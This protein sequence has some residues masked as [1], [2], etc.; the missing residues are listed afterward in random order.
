MKNEPRMK[1]ALTN[2]KVQH[3]SALTETFGPIEKPGIIGVDMASE[4][5]QHSVMYY[6]PM[7]KVYSQLNVLVLGHGRHGKDEF[8][9]RLAMR[10][11]IK[12]ASSSQFAC[13]RVVFPWFQ[14]FFPNHYENPE[15]CFN[16]RQNWR[17]L[18]HLLICEYNSEDKTRL[19][20][21][22]M[23][24]NNAYVGM[25]A[26]DELEACMNANIF[27]HVF[28]IDAGDRVEA[29]DVSSCSVEYDYETMCLVD[30][31]GDFEQLQEEVEL[32]ADMLGF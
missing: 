18:W 19:T 23:I 5:D 30:N 1:R 2:Y 17:A 10:I 21:E 16:D 11:G 9:A 14:Q 8:A 24:E 6:D 15:E 3:D 20:R 25:R 31:S 22:I 27:T 26:A 4:K 28:W 7:N 29:E 13:E 12:F 32:V